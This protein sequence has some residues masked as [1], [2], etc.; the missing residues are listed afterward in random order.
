MI[1]S[2]NV[3][4]VSDVAIGPAGLGFMPGGSVSGNARVTLPVSPLTRLMAIGIGT[5]VPRSPLTVDGV[6]LNEKS[7]SSF[8]TVRVSVPTLTLEK[9]ATIIRSVCPAFADTLKLEA[10]RPEQLALA[11]V[12]SLQPP[13]TALYGP[14]AGPVHTDTTVSTDDPHVENS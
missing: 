3:A 5:F 4:P 13:S 10:P 2:L 9:P 7:G 11:G 8:R 6:K 1:F 12:S 14:H